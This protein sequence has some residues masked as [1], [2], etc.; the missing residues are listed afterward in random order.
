[1]RAAAYL[2]AWA[3]CLL[4]AVWALLAAPFLAITGSG[5]RAMRLLVSFDQLG[6]AA[7]GGDEDETFSS[8]CW[9]RRADAPY[10]MLVRIIDWLFL[11][12]TEERDHC[13]SAF[14]SEQRA[15]S[16]RLV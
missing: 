16:R 14:E 2:C 13:R 10:G 7:A 9:R 8:R 11:R 12:A 1:M 3:A 6:N 5:A 4:V 15:C